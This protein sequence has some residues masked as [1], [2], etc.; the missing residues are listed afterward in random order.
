MTHP[1]NLAA[2]VAWHALTEATAWIRPTILAEAESGRPSRTVLPRDAATVRRVGHHLAVA[3][4]ELRADRV[5]ALRAGLTDTAKALGG[6]HSITDRADE[7]VDAERYAD[8]AKFDLLELIGEAAAERYD[9]ALD[10]ATLLDLRRLPIPDA[11]RELDP[12]RATVAAETLRRADRAVRGAC[13]IP[14]RV[15]PYEGLCPGCGTY[16]LVWETAA[17]D[18]AQW[19][20]LCGYGCRCGGEACG[21]G[22]PV[23]VA[24][25]AHRWEPALC[26]P[27]LISAVSSAQVREGVAA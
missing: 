22:L 6:V 8:R 11:L 2:L 27:V 3:Q 13:R 20:V 23:R 7:L 15:T 19:T 25:S 24:G 4:K 14:E 16:G 9:N 1:H 21:C 5:D 18:S 26:S 12:W 17:V 10:E